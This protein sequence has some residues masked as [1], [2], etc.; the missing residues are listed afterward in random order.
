MRL[1]I[2]LSRSKA[3][4]LTLQGIFALMICASL[5]CCVRKSQN[6]SQPSEETNGP[7]PIESVAF[8]PDGKIVASGSWDKTIKLWDVS[9]GAELRT[10]KG[11]SSFVNSVAFSPDGKILASGSGEGV[12]PV[13]NTIRLWNVSTGAELRTLKG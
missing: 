10:L 3:M 11:H 13:D 12:G 9:T 8:S 5:L 7:K 2:K 1:N 6:E 4:R